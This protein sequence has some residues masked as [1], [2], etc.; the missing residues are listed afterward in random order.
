[1]FQGSEQREGGLLHLRRE[2]SAPTSRRA[3]ST[4]RRTRTAPTTSRPCPPSNLETLLWLE[5]DRLATLPDAMTKEKLDNQRDVVKNERR[6]GL[7]N[8]PYGRWFKLVLE[9]LY[10]GRPSLLLARRSAATR[11]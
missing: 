10:P 1:M 5:S 6:Q 9:N 11:T 7:E 2:R 4:A 3:A 8:T